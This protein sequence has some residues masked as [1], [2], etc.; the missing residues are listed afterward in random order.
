MILLV[1]WRSTQLPQTPSCLKFW[2]DF[3]FLRKWKKT[4]TEKAPMNELKKPLKFWLHT[5][6]HVNRARGLYLFIPD[7][8]LTETLCS[9]KAMWEPCLALPTKKTW[10]LHVLMTL[11]NIFLKKFSF[12][13]EYQLTKATHNNYYTIM[14]VYKSSRSTQVK[15]KLESLR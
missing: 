9:S 10:D 15:E 11:W 2:N 8:W 14:I 7:C 5:S 13:I 1:Y 12:Y 3:I 4:E 6:L